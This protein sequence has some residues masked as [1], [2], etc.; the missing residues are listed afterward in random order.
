MPPYAGLCH[1][2]PLYSDMADNT[3]PIVKEEE[4]RA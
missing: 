3:L 1:N 4:M 2:F